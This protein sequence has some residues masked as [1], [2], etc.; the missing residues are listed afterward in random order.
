MQSLTASSMQTHAQ[1]QARDLKHE[2]KDWEANFHKKH[3]RAATKNDLIQMPDIARKYRE[4]SKLK[5]E[6]AGRRMSEQQAEKESAHIVLPMDTSTLAMPLKRKPSAIK[7]GEQ[8]TPSPVHL[9]LP[10]FRSK[11]QALAD[12]LSS[13]QADCDTC[14]G[15][16]ASGESDHDCDRREAIESKPK[17]RRRVVPLDQT[18]GGTN[19][20][21]Y[22][23]C[24]PA[25][26]ATTTKRFAD[27]GSG[28]DQTTEASRSHGESLAEANDA[29][30]RML[31]DANS[32]AVTA[33]DWD[34]V[35]YHPLPS[36]IRQYRQQRPAQVQMQIPIQTQKQAQ[37]LASGAAVGNSC[38]AHQP[39]VR[40]LNMMSMSEQEPTLSARVSV[41]MFKARAGRL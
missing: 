34:T 7:E 22:C 30:V 8:V 21:E 41:P 16:V 23:E 13:P 26:L 3:G 39:L 35:I 18:I 37:S 32:D 14:R 15:E 5:K 4:Y 20:A 12:M 17:R 36:L 24:A 31:V 33:T 19:N 29:G 28:S 11:Q 25:A 40:S 2:L 6:T 38:M 27:D 10:P 9:S 1:I